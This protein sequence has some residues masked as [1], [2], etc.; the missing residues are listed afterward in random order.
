MGDR[1]KG[2]YEGFAL[3]EPPLRCKINFPQQGRVFCS[4]RHQC[5]VFA[6]LFH[7]GC[8]SLAICCQARGIRSCCPPWRNRRRSSLAVAG[9]FCRGMLSQM[10][11]RRPAPKRGAAWLRLHEL[12][13][14]V[15][16]KSSAISCATPTCSVFH[17]LLSIRRSA[18]QHSGSL[19]FSCSVMTTDHSGIFDTFTPQRWKPRRAS[20]LAYASCSEASPRSLEH[21]RNN[22]RLANQQYRASTIRRRQEPYH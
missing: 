9:R 14:V 20:R 22:F 10:M 18:N 1:L 15:R 13:R 8:C 11:T 12:Y 2:I 17:Y 5:E 16:D 19:C 3:P 6:P 7:C 21:A 4:R